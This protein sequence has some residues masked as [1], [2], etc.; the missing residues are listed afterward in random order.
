MGSRWFQL[1]SREK[2]AAKWRTQ[3]EPHFGYLTDF[4]FTTI[5]DD[6]S[7]FWSLWV[8]YRSETAAVRINKSNEFRR[9][10]VH[11]IRLVDGELP[12]YPIW[13][14]DD[15]ID[16]TLLDNVVEVRQPSL[17]EHAGKLSGLTASRLDEQL[18]FW[19]RV[20]RDVASDFLEGDFASIDEAGELIRRRVAEHPQQVQVW[21][22]N[23]APLGSEAEQVTEVQAIVPPNVGVSVRRYWRGR[24]PKSKR[25]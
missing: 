6:D 10:E 9:A 13:I 21:I 1:A 3:V 20:L 18:G 14:T 22:P 17:V 16:W 12:A 11:L 23:D 8:Q 24:G 19:A 7:S 15:R 5:E 4:G 25:G 2:T